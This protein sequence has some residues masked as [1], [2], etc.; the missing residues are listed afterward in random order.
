MK[1]AL[2]SAL[3][4]VRHLDKASNFLITIGK[5]DVQHSWKMATIPVVMLGGVCGCIVGSVVYYTRLCSEIENTAKRERFEI[6]NAGNRERFEIENAGKRESVEIDNEANRERF[7]IDQKRI[8][9]ENAKEK[10]RSKIRI[11]EA[12]AMNKLQNPSS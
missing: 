10:E 12:I 3:N 7:E 4:S 2:I 1:T 9:M 5:M 8:E 11:E 6:E